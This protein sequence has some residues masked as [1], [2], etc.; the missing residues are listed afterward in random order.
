MTNAPA[1][2]ISVIMP[3]Y[4]TRSYLPATLKNIVDGQFSTMPPEQWE[5]IVV[6]DGST[7][8]SHLEVEPWSARFP[9]SVRLIRTQN[10]GASAAR[11]TGLAA[12]RGRYVYFADSDDLIRSGSLSRLLELT[13]EADP[14]AIKFLFRQISSEEYSALA[15]NVPPAEISAADVEH[16]TIREFMEKTYGLSRPMIHTST[17]QTIYKRRLLTDNNLGFDPTLT[18][19]ED[20]ALTWS[21]MPYVETV[22]YTPAQLFLYHQ[23]AGS[24][25]HAE[26][27]EREERYQFHRIEFSGKMISILDRIKQADLMNEK[28]LRNTQRNYMFGYYHSIID[29]IVKGYPLSTIARAMRLYRSYGGDVHPGRPRFTPFYDKA[30]MP[31]AVKRRRLLV[32]Y[33]LGSLIKLGF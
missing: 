20:E 14:D 22:A 25:S 9:Q 12:A 1:P 26:N 7:D 18:I 3:V 13:R 29:L 6:D 16:Y 10:Q 19:G 28:I 15:G 17:W 8:G 32:A 27:V 31:P 33:G 11:N 4:N 21:A 24:I 23:R 5:L 30:L 2:L